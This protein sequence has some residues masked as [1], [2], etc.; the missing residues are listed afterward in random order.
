MKFPSSKPGGPNPR[1]MELN[2]GTGRLNTYRSKSTKTQPLLPEKDAVHQLM[3][4]NPQQRSIL[5]YAKMT[6][7][8]AEGPQTYQDIIDATK[9]SNT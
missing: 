9:L 4:G 5:N 7:S 6:P 8:G 2:P 3:S 1:G